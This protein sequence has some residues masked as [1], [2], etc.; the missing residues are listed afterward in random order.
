MVNRSRNRRREVS[1]AGST[2]AKQHRRRAAGAQGRLDN[3]PP[4]AVIDIGSNSVRL[5]VYEGLTR[6]PTPIFNEKVLCGLGRKVQSTGLLAADAVDRALT[7]LRRFRALCDRIEVPQTYAIATAACRDARNGQDFIGRA[8]SICGTTIEVISGKREAE[9]AA[10]G[11]VSG[12]HRPDGIVGDLGGGSLELTDVHHH[13]L[14]RGLTFPLGGLALQDISSNSIKKAQK[15][16][17]KALDEAHLLSGGKG[18]SFYAIGGTWRSFARLH[19]W[20]KGYPLHVMHGYVIPAKEA[21][22]FASLV[23]RVDPSTLS[24]IEVVAN[25]RRPLLP[26]AA[27]VLDRLIA[28]ARPKDIVFSA[29]GVREGLLYTMLD[30]KERQEDPLIAAASELNLLRSRSPLHGHELIEWADRFMADSGLI[31]TADEK[32]LR[33]AA[34]LL[35]D[36]GWRA[37]PDYRGEQSLN[38]IA[39]AAFVG[40]DHPGRTFL[41]LA[42]FFRHVGLIEEELSPRLRELASARTLDRARVLGVALRVAYLISASTPGV[43]P[44]TPMTVERGR[45]VLRFA[46]G[47]QDLAG[48]RVFARLRQLARLIGR[49]PVMETK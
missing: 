49:E 9:L 21:Q 19:M 16:V 43:L 27:L 33:H 4:V 13:R 10:L 24:Q 3:G 46:R 25:A 42:V 12:F 5:V 14:G 22:E 35:A 48:D 6:S 32:R 20:Q 45:L 31:E 36:I 23:H 34:C 7:A 2:A 18:R 17:G 11:V 38:I 37:H 41:S 29:L 30:A 44:K 28:T 39:N 8:E 47:L 15:V 1:S 40:V 26:Y